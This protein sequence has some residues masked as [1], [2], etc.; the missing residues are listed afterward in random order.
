MSKPDA[1]FLAACALGL[2]AGCDR[3]GETETASPASATE[4]PVES[5][6]TEAP[7][8]VAPVTPGPATP[9]PAPAPPPATSATEMPDTFPNEPE[10]P[11]FALPRLTARGN[12]PF[13]AIDIDGTVLLWKTPENPQGKALGSSRTMDAGGLVFTGEDDGQPFRLDLRAQPCQ[14][15]MSGA[16]MEFTASWTHAGVSQTGCAQRAP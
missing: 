9:G 5:T 2:L 15:S 16:S 4:A 14:D 1:L 3:G 6:A 11:D 12:E 7:A 8:V 10:S 13:W